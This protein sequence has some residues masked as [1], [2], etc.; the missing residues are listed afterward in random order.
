MLEG[1]LRAAD[2]YFAFEVLFHDDRLLFL[3]DTVPRDG[4][5]SRKRKREKRK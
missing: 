2:T 1:P 3:L 5:V 4:S